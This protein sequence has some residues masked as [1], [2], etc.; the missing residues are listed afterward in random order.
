MKAISNCKLQKCVK[1]GLVLVPFVLLWFTL[2]PGAVNK[3]GVS[4][5]AGKS[6]VTGARSGISH[7][8]RPPLRAGEVLAAQTRLQSRF[9]QLPLS[10]EA[11]RGQTDARVKFL[12]RGH[13][14]SLFL[15]S[16]E[17]VLGLAKPLRNHKLEVRREL[18]V[19][20]GQSQKTV[21]WFR[22][23]LAPFMNRLNL[24]SAGAKG[25]VA[26]DASPS[27]EAL[28]R[29][30]LVG[31]NPAPRVT[32]L[33]Q[34]PGK[35][36]YLIGKDPKKWHTNVPTYAKVK[37]EGVYP[38]VDLIYYGNQGQ[39]EY[40]FVV[41][42]G[43][44]PRQIAL[45]VMTEG[46]RPSNEGPNGVRLHG[47]RRSPLHIDRNGDLFVG[48]G[49]GEVVFHKPLVYQ[50]A[51]D[52][53]QRA[54]VDSRYVLKGDHE[55]TFEVASYDRTKPLV[56]DP[57][58]R[59]STYI[60]GSGDELST[61]SGTDGI[62]VDPEGNAYIIGATSSIDFP[63]APG[64]LQTSFAGGSDSFG[65]PFNSI[66]ADAF[67]SKLN[68]RGDTIIY[69]TYLGGND[70]DCG[71]G[72]AVD[73]SGNAYVAGETLSTDFPVT[74]GTFQPACA[75][76]SKG[77]VDTFAAKLSRD[78]SALVYSTYLGGNDEDLFPMLA[79]DRFNNLYIQGST[80]SSDYP[81]T[82]GVFQPACAS[83]ANGNPDTYVTKLNSTGTAL[84]YSTYLGGSDFEFCGAQIAVDSIGSAY[85]NGVTCSTDFPTHNPLQGYAGG[86][87]AFLTKL[88]PAG[89][90]LVYSTYL[91]GS[92]FDIIFGTAID[93]SGNAYVSGSTASSDFPITPG[94]F[95]THLVAGSDSFVTK[96][97][98]TGSA[99]VYSTYLGG[100]GDESA[101]GIAVDSH[102]NAFVAGQTTS[103]DFPILKALQPA[104]AG[105]VDVF[106]SELNPTGRGLVSSTYLGGTGDDSANGIALDRLRRNIYVGGTTASG[107]FPTLHAAQP[108]FGGGT[109]DAFVVEISPDS[110]PAG[111]LAS[112]LSPS[113]AGKVNRGPE[114]PSANGIIPSW[115]R[116]MGM[117]RKAAR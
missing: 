5:R 13:G 63:V 44:D 81:T 24:A 23:L 110:P 26:D 72:I 67:V 34:L 17:V 84:V 42:P 49:G 50:A 48:T 83:C 12:S 97:N 85:V 52:S 38:G 90:A 60:G 15:T 91:G 109:F 51:T 69:S 22:A 80:F 19:M 93:L 99:P 79:L 65:C 112:R 66:S 18:P 115:K 100:A 96:I 20:G 40:D 1:V 75:S 77:M 55:V 117:A 54:A 47:E 37:Y 14:Y 111:A 16:D 94:A 39:L 68:A 86:C 6:D 25:V 33:A 8:N 104:N 41:A 82:A 35:S 107:D 27:T 53:G 88:N 73:P 92:D 106:V 58:L 28:L 64:A 101:E 3:R 98:S 30:K 31:V 87:D 2:V 46:I 89:T 74:P 36:N 61:P 103:T 114:M 32:P 59:Y 43:V 57:V 45:D 4:A 108:Q 70:D 7:Q 95:Q 9:G 102:G 78:G 116:R 62:A 11:N 56:I 71:E 29:M 105:G 76:C 10:F 21:D 113:G